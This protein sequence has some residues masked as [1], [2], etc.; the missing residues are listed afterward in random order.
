MSPSLSI[1]G[2]LVLPGLNPTL[3]DV[4]TGT[5]LG[6]SKVHEVVVPWLIQVLKEYFMV[7]GKTT[8]IGTSEDG[9]VLDIDVTWDVLGHDGHFV[10]F[11]GL[12]EIKGRGKTRD[13]GTV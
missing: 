7:I 8:P 2:P 6:S 12:E 9:G 10:G 13:T 11:L 5:R 1:F 4:N 3:N